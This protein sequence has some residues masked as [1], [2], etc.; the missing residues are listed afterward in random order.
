VTDE[1]VRELVSRV[2]RAQLAWVNGT[3]DPLYDLS[4]GTIFAPFGGPAGGGPGLSAVQAAAAAHFHDGTTEIEVVNT[5]VTSDVVCLAMIERNMVRFD[6][7]EEK[8][9][10]ILRSTVVFRRSSDG[11]TLLHRHA[12]PLIERRDLGATLELLPRSV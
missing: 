12:D 1:D 9:P 2:E 4:E 7:D 10:W 3:L 11:W 6:G 5:I 8:R